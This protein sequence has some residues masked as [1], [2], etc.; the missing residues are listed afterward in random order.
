VTAGREG[1]QELI[2]RFRAVIEGDAVDDRGGGIATGLDGS[3]P[4][5]PFDCRA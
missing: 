1:C 2:G 5:S 4:I 3:I